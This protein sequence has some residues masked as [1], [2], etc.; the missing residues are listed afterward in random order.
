[1]IDPVVGAIGGEILGQFG[2]AINAGRQYRQTKKMQQ[3]Q[4]DGNKEMGEFN[5][6]QS[7]RMWQDTNYGAQREQM[8]KAGINVGLMYG[9]GGGGGVTAQTPAGQV[10][11]GQPA[12]Q[13]N[14]QGAGMGIQSAIMQAQAENLKA[15]T[16]KKEEEAKEIRERTPT[17]G[18]GIR[19]TE[20]E[21][22]K[23]ASDNNVSIATMK[24]ILAE[25]ETE[26]QK[27]ANI[28][29]DTGLKEAQA[30]KTVAET[31]RIGHEIDQIK[32]NNI[33]TAERVNL[34]KMQQYEISE[35]LMQKGTELSQGWEHL[36]QKDREI[37][38]RAFEAELRAEYPTLGQAGGS[39]VN[40][41]MKS[42]EYTGKKAAG[43]NQ[44]RFH[45]RTGERQQW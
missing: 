22:V 8:E 44:G 36:S 30:G 7:M 5:R 35:K 21:I 16:N 27:P 1:M 43:T 3:M 19:K 42:L 10:S 39:I 33:L 45:N 37:K 17:H 9:M 14:G 23:L 13:S 26:E 18:V 6:K 38:L 12:Q 25:T 41:L 31:G 11:G 28:N 15:D 4:I 29:A 34:T 24:K 40:E 32:I 2:N 20:A